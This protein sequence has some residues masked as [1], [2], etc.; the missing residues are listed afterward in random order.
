[1][2]KVDETENNSN[3]ASTVVE[4][5]TAS[6]IPEVEADADNELMKEMEQL[7]LRIDGKG[8]SKKKHSADEK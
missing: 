5:P 2:V 7:K 4:A 1:M 6:A 3:E 8:I